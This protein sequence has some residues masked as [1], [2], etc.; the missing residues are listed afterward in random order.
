MTMVI[1]IASLFVHVAVQLEAEVR[2]VAVMHHIIIAHMA[3][4]VI[5]VNCV[6]G[7]KECAHTLTT[8]IPQRCGSRAATTENGECNL[9][10]LILL[11]HAV[12]F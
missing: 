10:A 4:G 11:P 12:P 8:R 9:S 7:A 6:P 1:S 5:E 2:I 3:R